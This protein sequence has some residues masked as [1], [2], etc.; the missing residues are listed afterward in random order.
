M[1]RAMTMLL[2]C[3]LEYSIY[4]QQ[5]AFYTVLRKMLGVLLL[6]I[7]WCFLLRAYLTFI[8]SSAF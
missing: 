1:V 2:T 3:V 7:I 4:H 5:F 6:L 8:L